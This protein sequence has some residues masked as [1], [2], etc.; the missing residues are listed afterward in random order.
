MALL[1][2]KHQQKFQKFLLRVNDVGKL[3]G[4][5]EQN[6]KSLSIAIYY[7]YHKSKIFAVNQV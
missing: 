5:G 3:H 2:L 7:F 6:Q 1:I 4:G